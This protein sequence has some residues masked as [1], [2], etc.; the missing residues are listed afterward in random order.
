VAVI[1]AKNT[2]RLTANDT[3]EAGAVIQQISGRVGISKNL[4]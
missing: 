3:P 4:R 2:G 1:L